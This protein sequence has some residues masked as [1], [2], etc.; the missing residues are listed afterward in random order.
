MN[1]GSLHPLLGPMRT[2][3]SFLPAIGQARINRWLICGYGTPGTF[4][5]YLGNRTDSTSRRS[6]HP[7]PRF[8]CSTLVGLHRRSDWETRLQE[9]SCLL[10]L[11]PRL[12]EPY[13]VSRTFGDPLSLPRASTRPMIL[14]TWLKIT[15]SC[16]PPVRSTK[17]DFST[18]YCV[19]LCSVL[20]MSARL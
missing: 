9:R 2:G 3:L 19:L 8:R 1:S 14:R 13:L 16:A 12:H 18:N 11:I 7:L 5:C 15:I 4:S 20:I 17:V 10:H 6:L